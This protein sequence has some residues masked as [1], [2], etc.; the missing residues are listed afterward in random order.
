MLLLKGATVDPKDLMLPAGA[1][2]AQP[3]GGAPTPI[4]PQPNGEAA[5]TANKWQAFQEKVLKE[6][7]G[8][9]AKYN[10]A[11]AKEKERKDLE[12]RL[13]ERLFEQKQEKLAKEKGKVKSRVVEKDD[14]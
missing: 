12:K 14:D 5:P 9:D 6:K 2:S 4:S 1:T 13:L 8:T 7:K 10:Y 11:E 3:N